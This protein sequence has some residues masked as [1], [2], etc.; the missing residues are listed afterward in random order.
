MI[1]DRDK[2]VEKACTSKNTYYS[3]EQA[4]ETALFIRAEYQEKVYPYEC[5]YCDNWHIGHK[6]T[7]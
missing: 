7:D 4:E 6:F 2:A 1:E 5:Q 3:K